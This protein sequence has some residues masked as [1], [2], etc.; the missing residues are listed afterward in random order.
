MRAQR[1]KTGFHRIG[2]VGAILCLVPAVGSFLYAAFVVST[3]EWTD[4]R[5]QEVGFAL[6]LG[7]SWL[8]AGGVFY[9]LSR[10]LGWIVA[11]ICR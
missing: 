11:W 2:L 1:I 9:A 7:V 10:A 5:L 3:Q 8:V 4:N 6:L